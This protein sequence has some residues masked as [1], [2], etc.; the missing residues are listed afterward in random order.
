MW[1][2]LNSQICRER[3]G[4]MVARVFKER[5]VRSVA[6]W[7]R[8]FFC[9]MKRVSE[10]DSG[11]GHTTKWV[12]LTLL[13]YNVYH[14]NFYVTWILPQL[15][16]QSN[17]TPH[18]GLENSFS[19]HP[20]FTG[21]W[22]LYVHYRKIWFCALICET[23]WGQILILFL[24]K[25]PITGIRLTVNSRSYQDKCFI[26]SEAFKSLLGTDLREQFVTF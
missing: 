3:N 1:N 22:I 23:L 14:G 9:K 12:Y 11:D 10:M 21:V 15:K 2:T 4:R 20:W 18:S 17:K 7:Y 6:S 24:G 25:K 16:Q 13:S 8:V 26:V 5:G 19:C